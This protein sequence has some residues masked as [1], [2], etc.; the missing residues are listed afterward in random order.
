M[1]VFMYGMYLCVCVCKCIYIY[2]VTEFL[3]DEYPKALLF[4]DKEATSPLFKSLAIQF[5]GRMRMGKASSAGR[6]F[7]SYIY[8]ESELSYYKNAR[9]LTFE[10]VSQTR[11]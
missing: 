8:R 10:N 4:S 11:N 1:Y 7:I 2:D 6:Q 3:A 5:K 9:A